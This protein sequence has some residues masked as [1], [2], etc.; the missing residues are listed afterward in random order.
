M[1]YNAYVWIQN[2]TI[3]LGHDGNGYTLYTLQV[4][5]TVLRIRHASEDVVF[6]VRGNVSTDFIRIESSDPGRVVVSGSM[7]H[8]ESSLVTTHDIHT[9]PEALYLVTT[10]QDRVIGS[11]RSGLQSNLNPKLIMSVT[12]DGRL[13]VTSIPENEAETHEQRITGLENRLLDLSDIRQSIL[14]QT[15]TTY[16]IGLEDTRWNTA[17]QDTV[18]SS[19]LVFDTSYIES[20]PRDISIQGDVTVSGT[21]RDANGILDFGRVG[22]PMIPVSSDSYSIGDPEKIWAAVHV[23]TTYTNTI[24]PIDQPYTSLLGDLVVS[25]LLVGTD[26]GNII[27]DPEYGTL[28]AHLNPAVDTTYTLGSDTFR[29]SSVYAPYISG[30]H[31]GLGVLVDMYVDS[32]ILNPDGTVFDGM[33]WTRVH[34]DIISPTVPRDLGT[35]EY[36]WEHIYASRVSGTIN[37][38][39][40][41]GS[42][43]SIR[44]KHGVSIG[45][46]TSLW[47]DVWA[48]RLHGELGTEYI[49]N[50]FGV[51]L[52]AQTQTLHIGTEMDSWD[53][54]YA[55]NVDVDFVTTTNVYVSQ[56][57]A[58][59]SI[60]DEEI[61]W[62][63]VWT[64]TMHGNIDAQYL[65]GHAG[66]NILEYDASLI[67]RISMEFGSNVYPT[68]AFVD[69]ISSGVYMDSNAT[70]LSWTS[71]GNTLASHWV[72]DLYTTVY[73]DMY[74]DT[75][76][77]P[78]TDR[79][80]TIGFEDRPWDDVYSVNT[81]IQTVVS[82]PEHVF[83]RD[84]SII[85]YLDD[86]DR[87]MLPS[88]GVSIG[89]EGRSWGNVYILTDVDASVFDG[90]GS[91]LSNI[92]ASK[93]DSGVANEAYLPDASTLVPGIV[94]LVDDSTTTDAT[95]S[96]TANMILT[97]QTDT[98]TRATQETRIDSIDGID[99]QG[100]I[101]T[102]IT[103]Q[104]TNT[105]D[106]SNIQ[107]S[108]GDAIRVLE[109]DTFGHGLTSS[110]STMDARYYLE[111]DATS[112]FVHV[113]GNTMSGALTVPI[114]RAQNA[115]VDG[116]LR[117]EGSFF[118]IDSRT[119]ITDAVRITNTGDS[120]A[121]SIEQAGNHDIVRVVD[122][123]TTVASWYNG[124]RVYLTSTNDEFLATP[125]DQRVDEL[126]GIFG[127]V[128]VHDTMSITRLHG[129]G[130]NLTIN[131]S[132]FVS[133]TVP[134]QNLPN[135][136]IGSKGTVVLD[137]E[138]FEYGTV[139]DTVTSRILT[140]V[141]DDAETR[142]L[143]TTSILAGG[144]LVG[145]GTLTSS[146]SIGHPVV[147]QSSVTSL[148]GGEC[149]QTIDIDTFGHVNVLDPVDLDTLY[150]SKATTDATFVHG[151]GGTMTGSLVIQD[152]ILSV[153]GNT[154][155]SG[156]KHVFGQPEGVT[157]IIENDEASIQWNANVVSGNALYTGSSYDIRAD[158][159]VQDASIQFSMADSTDAASNIVWTDGLIL[160][161]NG[162]STVSLT[163][164]SSLYATA[165]S[166]IGTDIQHIRAPFIDKG[167]CHVD[168]LRK[169]SVDH[170]GIV[171]LEDTLNSVSIVNAVTARRMR[172]VWN[173]ASESAFPSIFITSGDGLVGSG[174]LSDGTISI[175]HD[176]T[177]EQANIT[178]QDDRIVSTF[179]FDEFGHVILT[180]TRALDTRYYTQQESDARFISIT[181]DTVSGNM[182][183]PIISGGAQGITHIDAE[184]ITTGV[185]SSDRLPPASTLSPGSVQLYD[186]VDSG[187][188]SLAVTANS[189]RAIWDSVEIR[190]FPSVSFTPGP[191]LVGGGTLE[192]T[193]TITHATTST[194]A[195]TMYSEGT[196]LASVDF[197]TFGHVVN[198]V[199]INLDSRLYTQSQSDTLYVNID[200]DTV[201]GNISFG[202]TFR[203][204]LRFHG[205]IDGIGV[206]A[207][208]AYY[209][210]SGNMAWYIGGVHDDTTF[211]PGTGGLVG[212][213]LGN[214]G[215]VGISTVPTT[216]HMSVEGSIMCPGSLF[217]GTTNEGIVV[218]T[219]EYGSVQTTAGGVTAWKGYSIQNE[220]AF[221]SE[222]DTCGL[223]NSLDARWLVECIS[224]GAVNMTYQGQTTLS[225]T[226][227]GVFIQDEFQTTSN[228]IGYA[229][230]KRLKT[231]VQHLDGIL[232]AITSIRGYRF[233]WDETIE[234]L[235]MK[236]LDIGL[237][238]QDLEVFPECLAPAPFDHRDDGTSV[239]GNSYLTIQYDKVHAIVIQGVRDMCTHMDTES[240][241]FDIMDSRLLATR[242][243]LEMATNVLESIEHRIIVS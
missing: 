77:R 101:E 228:V 172:D 206:Q 23:D 214:T 124:G 178:F 136:S 76:I 86:F 219:G 8:I 121:M 56:D 241:R 149:I 173:R 43:V 106:M 137:D 160:D 24:D 133:G 27:P 174:I 84:E 89:K 231:S 199:G 28:E 184:N 232:D 6:T 30:G 177:S 140:S 235:P 52:L 155:Y 87:S 82:R 210:S 104:H 150:T 100:T 134:I 125:V 182:S 192:T 112:R 108:G 72:D 209:R 185:F 96:A 195:N 45:R 111:H 242:D 22:S 151:T 18:R 73:T 157:L 46:S 240:R 179:L 64:E 54:V 109:I 175:Q 138:V 19:T 143:K 239:S 70:H 68:L 152:N 227:Y 233:T 144:G 226:T 193:N 66:A 161:T 200:G 79:T 224:N 234:G 116:D 75:S 119:T 120:P 80:Y 12:Q 131:G 74:S 129:I 107:G 49:Q 212:L 127:N 158:E 94:R 10:K 201:T 65:Y 33:D 141:Y 9:V 208:T 34:S 62:E 229:S 171:Q 31:D 215:R 55:S 113:S 207:N 169:A 5:G 213:V 142:A 181:G 98:H 63:T 88:P 176:T 225:T 61:S 170:T 32:Y 39:Q 164:N 2:D 60:G 78:G 1:D 25:G 180:E 15:H 40:T 36:Q 71:H 194:Q 211:S 102:N 14:P 126:L 148:A 53:R 51:P 183:V 154:R 220:Y 166:G 237:L 7:S 236:G 122:D 186:D 128:L 115:N 167:T 243:R 69:D 230:D 238:A 114:V 50:S 203:Q 21:A 67:R 59:A 165:F 93:I 26:G 153:D 123:G 11:L 37:I 85:L 92:D 95:T 223:F 147:N 48:S 146:R 145:G 191:G 196:V 217:T 168:R 29:W 90:D 162:L 130:T 135:A 189:M 42:F 81:T 3:I 163:T 190:A 221:V 4:D 117:I 44:P 38:S 204:P 83:V 41:N 47:T 222:S 118:T 103:F 202:S 13:G 159:N 188:V 187:S 205:A 105:S 218:P 57:N 156:Y 99:G 20:I 17:R 97:L 16:N 35:A 197:D 91:G 216:A 110:T 198:L 139:L 132:S 58:S